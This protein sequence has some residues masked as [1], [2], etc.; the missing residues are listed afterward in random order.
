MPP[1]LQC[2]QDLQF[3][4]ALHGDDPV[5]F[6]VEAAQQA[7]DAGARQTVAA[8]D[9]S[10]IPPSNQSFDFIESLLVEGQMGIASPPSR[11]PC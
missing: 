1:P 5:H 11:L 9:K 4:H 10:P 7:G 3:L 2:A 8:H 6:A